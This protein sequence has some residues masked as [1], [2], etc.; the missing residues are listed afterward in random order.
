[1]FLGLTFWFHMDPNE[2]TRNTFC[3]FL[4]HRRFS[5]CLVCSKHDFEDAC[6]FLVFFFWLIN[7]IWMFSCL[8][9]C[10]LVAQW[11][12]CFSSTPQHWLVL[13]MRFFHTYTIGDVLSIHVLLLWL[14]LFSSVTSCMK[15]KNVPCCVVYNPG[16]FSARGG[17]ICVPH[18]NSSKP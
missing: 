17:S 9:L 2:W 15:L 10:M 18:V 13:T 1:M 6:G 16:P 11:A 5:F 7:P 4:R 3:S 14:V 12:I 8:I